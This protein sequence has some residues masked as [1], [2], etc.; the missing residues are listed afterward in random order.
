[1]SVRLEERGNSMI[2]DAE[3]CVVDTVPEYA[4]NHTCAQNGVA[5]EGGVT[6]VCAE[7][8]LNC[9]GPGTVCLVGKLV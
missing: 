3:R 7:N 1:M 8:E 6:A 9:Q 2:S 5:W 4:A